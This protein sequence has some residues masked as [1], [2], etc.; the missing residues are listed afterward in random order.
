MTDLLRRTSEENVREQEFLS[1]K[2]EAY[3]AVSSR[4]IA[5]R[6]AEVLE[7]YINMEARLLEIGDRGDNSRLMYVRQKIRG[8]MEKN[9]KEPKY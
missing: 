4:Q 3:K 5:L 2:I 9:T 6:H 7:K 1:A 8:L